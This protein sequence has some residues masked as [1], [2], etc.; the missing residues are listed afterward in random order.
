MTKGLDSVYCRQ[1][2]EGLGELTFCKTMGGCF[3]FYE[4]Y[5][6][7]GTDS[8]KSLKRK[9][10][11]N[12]KPKRMEKQ[13]WKK[14]LDFAEIVQSKVG[15]FS[16]LGD[17][18]KLSVQ[19]LSFLNLMIGQCTVHIQC[20]NSTQISCFRVIFLRCHSI[21]LFLQKLPRNIF[22]K[23]LYYNGYLII[24]RTKWVWIRQKR[25]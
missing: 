11:R 7:F 9:V 6:F 25:G 24:H 13:F 19:N 10:S 1:S 14:G 4:W 3:P 15:K 2:G 22:K 12:F 20:S 17:K 5:I 18:K 23:T 21:K 8:H 16:L